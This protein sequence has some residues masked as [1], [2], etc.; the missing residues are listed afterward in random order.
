M[1]HPPIFFFSLTFRSTNIF[2]S[3]MF[4]TLYALFLFSCCSWWRA[5]REEISEME[6]KA[7]KGRG[8][9][10]E[11]SR[12]SKREEVK[13]RRMMWSSSS[14]SS[15]IFSYINSCVCV[16]V[17]VILTRGSLVAWF[18]RA[19]RGEN[20]RHLHPFPES[21]REGKE[22]HHHEHEGREMQFRKR[23]KAGKGAL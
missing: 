22:H 19:G 12:S 23:W 3:Y 15:Y 4:Y 21:C 10:T 16:C 17:C 13:R 7:E 8:S 9:E 2:T 18:K 20:L 6:R 14:S 5:G 1:I 11:S